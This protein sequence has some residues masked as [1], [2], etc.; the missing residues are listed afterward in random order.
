MYYID[1][2]KISLSEFAFYLLPLTQSY[3]DIS[4]ATNVVLC[5]ADCCSLDPFVQFTFYQASSA[6]APPALLLSLDYH[7]LFRSACAWRASLLSKHAGSP[8]SLGRRYLS[9][10]VCVSFSLM[11]SCRAT[12][13]F[14]G[15]V[16]HFKLKASFYKDIQFPLIFKSVRGKIDQNRIVNRIKNG[17]WKFN[18]GI[19]V[20]F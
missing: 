5:W 20:I 10:E 6:P 14:S 1:K 8:I 15:C 2:S 16:L 17:K 4:C 13:T 12:M 7:P 11:V 19:F 3:E 18:H 9:E